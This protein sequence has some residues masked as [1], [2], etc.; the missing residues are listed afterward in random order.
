MFG[1]RVEPLTEHRTLETEPG[2]ISFAP[3]AGLSRSRG[4]PSRRFGNRA[5]KDSSVT[6]HAARSSSAFGA[7]EV[8]NTRPLSPSTSSQDAWRN[9]RRSYSANSGFAA[10]TSP[11]FTRAASIAAASGPV[12]ITSPT[13][14]VN[15]SDSSRSYHISAT[16]PSGLRM[17]WNSRSAVP[18]SN[19][20]NA[21]AATTHS[22]TASGRP[23]ASAAPSRYRGGGPA[24]QGVASARRR[25]A[26]FG[27][28]PITE[29]PRSAN[30]REAMPVPQPTSTSAAPRCSPAQNDGPHH[31]VRVGWPVNRV[32]VG[33][34]GKP[35]GRITT[36]GGH[37]PSVDAPGRSCPSALLTAFTEV[38]RFPGS[39]CQR[40]S[41]CRRKRPARPIG[42]DGRDP[43]TVDQER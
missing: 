16:Q 33:Q 24:G 6:P 17:R 12:R 20:W 26:E 38:L 29:R 10:N 30:S 15:S 22:A 27:S 39:R 42:G 21:W 11:D 36:W 7:Y 34:A 9:L 13:A 3:C 28:T 37:P 1:I 31:F 23:V 4:E 18:A 8:V 14:A 35:T 25:I 43:K 40:R 19:Q 2:A 41:K 32:S 5:C